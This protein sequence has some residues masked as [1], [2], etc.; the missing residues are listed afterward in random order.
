MTGPAAFALISTDHDLVF[1]H[2]LTTTTTAAAAGLMT[3]IPSKLVVLPLLVGAG[4]SPDFHL[5]DHH[6]V[7]VLYDDRDAREALDFHRRHGWSW[8]KSRAQWVLGS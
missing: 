5:D 4:T 8:I 1:S 2:L 7:L 6:V 3:V